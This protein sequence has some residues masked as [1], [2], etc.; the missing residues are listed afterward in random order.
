M[1]ERDPA[2]RAAGLRFRYRA[3]PAVL[4]GIDLEAREGEL[5]CLLGPNGSGKTTLL[6]C[7]ASLVRPEGGRVE[8]LGRSSAS[9]SRRELARRIAYVPQFPAAAGAFTVREVVLMG[10]YAHSGPLG[11]PSPEDLAVAELALRMT[12]TLAIADRLFGELSG[13]ESQC[14]M[15][16]RALAQQPRILLLDEPTSHLDLRNQVLVHGMLRRIAHDWPM[17][18]VVAS[19]DVNLAGR[20]ADRLV[21]LLA[22]RIVAS[23]PP[24]EVIR[25]ETLEETYGTRVEL[26]DPGGGAPPLV[27]AE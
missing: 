1:S 4:Q 21:F 11:I 25:K 8:V 15:I 27:V 5:V 19:H 18:V 23:G 13:G 14:A 17:A 26:V 24:A 20:F 9:L 10:R 7:L 2:V 16:A 3:G 22:G 12:G 6:R